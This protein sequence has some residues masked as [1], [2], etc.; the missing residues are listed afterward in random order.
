MTQL[1]PEVNDLVRVD[2][3]AGDNTRAVGVPT[4][5]ESVDGFDLTISTPRYRG[6][7]DPPL[8]GTQVS[9]HWAAPRGLHVVATELVDIEHAHVGL[10]HLS[11][12]TNVTVFQRRR[13]VRAAV[14]AQVT[15]VPQVAGLTPVVTGSLSDLSE[16]SLRARVD[17]AGALAVG[18]RVN[19]QLVIG[20]TSV[21]A[22]GTTLCLR[23]A[24]TARQLDV[25]VVFD[26]EPA[27][28]EVIRRAV[29]QQQRIDRGR[30]DR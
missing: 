6:D 14:P 5:I 8:P 15:L 4:R 30:T 26:D 10:W 11:V 12:L 18:G 20:G 2:V 28:A 9:V 17:D 16:G 25:V 1:L 3:G 27:Q 13:F 22:T 7:I 29:I 19:V 24:G 21:A 23:S